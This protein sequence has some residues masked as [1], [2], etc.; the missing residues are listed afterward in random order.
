MTNA[1]GDQAKF[2]MRA[3]AA[4]GTAETPADGAFLTL[5]YYSFTLPPTRELNEDDGIYGDAYPGEQVAGLEGMTGSLVVPMGFS[6]IGHHLQGM[7]GAPV[8]TE[9]QTGRYQHVFK[10]PATQSPVL[11]TTGLSYID[12]DKHRI[13]DSV[14][15]TGLEQET[16]KE[17]MFSRVSFNVSGRAESKLASTIDAT[18]VSYVDD[19]VPVK[20]TSGLKVDGVA[21]AGVT[22]FNFSLTSGVEMDQETINGT[23][24][25]DAV[26]TGKWGLTGRI[27]ARYRDDS[28][29]DLGESGQL[30]DW[31]V[32]F[33]YDDDHSLEYLLHNVRVQRSGIPVNNRETISQSFDI[34]AAR[35]D[36][37][38]STLTATLINTVA[39]YANPT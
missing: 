32:T 15:Y 20:L 39:D 14:V 29:Y 24:F 28:Y 26:L 38:Q 13:H 8:T 23:P 30:V 17:G 3:Q 12:V 35:P 5:P 36:A 19:I 31:T 37:G 10:T 22:G 7:L 18:P 2:F 6:S 33:P 21:A 16:R 1:R 4:F 27:D 11:H 9:L 25:A 34:S